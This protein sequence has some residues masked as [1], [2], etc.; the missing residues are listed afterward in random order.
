MKIP[1]LA[2]LAGL[3]LT[4][5]CA[6][7]PDRLWDA[8]RAALLNQSVAEVLAARL[9]ADFP[10]GGTVLVI[11]HPRSEIG[12]Q[13]AGE[14]RFTALREQL[15][16]APFTFKTGGVDVPNRK[17]A[18]PDAAFVPLQMAGFWATVG[19]W[20]AREGQPVAV[21]LLQGMSPV[22]TPAEA[23]ALPPLY[24]TV[25]VADPAYNALVTAGEA[26]FLLV[27]Q[28]NAAAMQATEKDF[29]KQTA[30]DR[31]AEFYMFLGE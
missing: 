13:E 10:Q 3:F 11:K 20:A 12:D 9:R 29:E 8:D 4:A 27:Q 23:A 6:P 26:R 15:K 24:G 28:R 2:A 16:A 21:L 5:S 25:P 22:P 17:R 18:E 1:C 30:R 7:K 14:A 19:E 31:V